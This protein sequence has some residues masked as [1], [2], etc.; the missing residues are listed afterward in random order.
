METWILCTIIFVFQVI[1]CVFFCSLSYKFMESKQNRKQIE[2][3]AQ[4][5]EYLK[6][7][8]SVIRDYILS[9]IPQEK[10]KEVES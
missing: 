9:T 3:N 2:L 8:I 1:L 7:D 6:Q 4:E 10:I 5:I